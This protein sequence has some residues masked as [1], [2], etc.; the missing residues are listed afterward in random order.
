MILWACLNI[1]HAILAKC[2][3]GVWGVPLHLRLRRW[4]IAFLSIR[5]THFRGV[6]GRERGCDDCGFED[7]LCILDLDLFCI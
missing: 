4:E 3:G 2:G 5:I 6:K 7:A 1:T